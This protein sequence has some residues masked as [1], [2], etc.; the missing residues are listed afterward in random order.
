MSSFTNFQ[1]L[2]NCLKI[3]AKLDSPVQT[4]RGGTRDAT[5]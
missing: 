2:D 1:K 3:D 4:E 5:Y